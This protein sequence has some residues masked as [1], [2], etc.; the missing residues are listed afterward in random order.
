MFQKRR[1]LQEGGREKIEGI[2]THKIV[3][4][5]QNVFKN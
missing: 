2:V 1:A 4:S 5:S 3:F